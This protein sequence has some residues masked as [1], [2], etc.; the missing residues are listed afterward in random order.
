MDSMCMVILSD[1]IHHLQCF[2]LKI[3]MFQ[4]LVLLLTSGD[5]RENKILICWIPQKTE[6]MDRQ[7]VRLVFKCFV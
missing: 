1:F 3:T 4:K 7:I 5:H 2:K 6:T